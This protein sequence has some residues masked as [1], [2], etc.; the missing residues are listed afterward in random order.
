MNIVNYPSRGLFNRF[1]SDVARLYSDAF[2]LDSYAEAPARQWNPAVDV[3]E[4]E[5]SFLLRADVPGAN[6]DDIEVTVDDGVLTLKGKRELQSASDTQ[7]YKRIERAQGAF[8]RQFTLPDTASSDGITASFEAGVL[9]VT[10]PKSEKS[11]PR[12]IPV[13]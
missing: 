2:G 11:Q 8:T 6:P 7:G 10:I 9:T 4:N 13:N 12:R 1:P 5:T 3:L